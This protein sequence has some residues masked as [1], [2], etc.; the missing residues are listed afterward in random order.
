MAN[1]KLPKLPYNWKEQPQ[2]FERYWDD[3][4]R[5][6]EEALTS[7]L[8]I[9]AI[10]AALVSVNAAAAAAAA[11]AT[12]A[13]TAADNAQTSADVAT[14]VATTVDVRTTEARQFLSTQ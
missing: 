9:P 11:S 3:A 10:E 6:I 7:I 8:S 2:L 14:V 12:A 4:T 5:K 1:F 13:Q